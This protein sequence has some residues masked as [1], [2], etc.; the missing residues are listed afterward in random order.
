MVS[1]LL[2]TTS[3]LTS[4]VRPLSVVTSWVKPVLAVRD[5][6]IRNDN[7]SFSQLFEATL[8]YDH[9]FDKLSLNAVGGYS[10][11]DFLLPGFNVQAGNFVTDQSSETI[12][13][14]LLTLP[15]VRQL[16]NQ[17][18]KWF[19]ACCFFWKGKFELE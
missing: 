11:Q 17:L 13:S 14:L 19:K 7:E 15:M 1:E 16:G 6:S 4:L 9:T 18:Q 3:S 8:T 12:Y 10:Y 5:M 2:A